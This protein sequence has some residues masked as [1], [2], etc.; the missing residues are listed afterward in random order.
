MTCCCLSLL[1][2][3]LPW[4]D[5]LYPQT[6]SQN[7]LAAPQAAYARDVITARKKTTKTEGEKAGGT[8]WVIFIEDLHVFN[9]ILTILHYIIT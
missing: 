8:R 4:H 9:I 5:G 1:L 7:E 2:L 6:I 3:C